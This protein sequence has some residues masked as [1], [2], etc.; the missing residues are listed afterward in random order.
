MLTSGLCGALVIA[1]PNHDQ[2][3]VLRDALATALPILVQKPLVTNIADGLAL[4]ARAQGRQANRCC[5]R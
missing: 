2:V 1:S 3:A 4:L 5:R